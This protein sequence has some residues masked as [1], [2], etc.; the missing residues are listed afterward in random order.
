M[1]KTLELN[2]VHEVALFGG[3]LIAPIRFQ[4]DEGY[5]AIRVPCDL[6]RYQEKAALATMIGLADSLRVAGASFQSYTRHVA[7][8]DDQMDCVRIRRQDVPVNLLPY[9]PTEI[10]DRIGIN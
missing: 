3:D 9:L 1:D 10:R 8:E 4:L 2:E 7:D 6:D 5:L